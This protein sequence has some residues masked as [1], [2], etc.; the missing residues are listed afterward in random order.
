[1]AVNAEELAVLRAMASGWTLKAQ[2]DLEGRKTF[3]LYALDGA[4]RPVAAHVVEALRTGDLIGSN[5]KFPA[6]TFWLTAAGRQR[7][8]G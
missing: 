7:V 8:T 6:A 1:M 3:C 4:T 5:H 2:R